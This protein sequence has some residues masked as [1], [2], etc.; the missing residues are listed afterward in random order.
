[1]IADKIKYIA[2]FILGIFTHGTSGDNYRQ[3][4]LFLAVIVCLVALG[5]IGLLVSAGV[6]ILLN[7]L[8]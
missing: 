1:M 7:N 6:M 2:D 4:P 5:V 3:F 8:R